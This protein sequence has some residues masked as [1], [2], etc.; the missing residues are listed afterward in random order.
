MEVWAQTG[1]ESASRITNSI[2]EAMKATT[3]NAT[4]TQDVEFIKRL[5]G[6]RMGVDIAMCDEKIFSL[7]DYY[8]NPS[9]VFPSPAASQIVT[10]IELPA[11]IVRGGRQIPESMFRPLFRAMHQVVVE[12]DDYGHGQASDTLAKAQDF[13]AIFRDAGSL[14][15]AGAMVAEALKIRLCKILGLDTADKTIHDRMDSFGVDSLIALELRN[16]LAKEV[17]AHLAM[18]EILGDVELIDTG[19]TAARKSEF[20]QAGWDSAK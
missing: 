7:F 6:G 10:D 3:Y 12:G 8:C 1:P 16:W 13:A 20:R 11:L 19:L 18:Y 9:T 17:R 4:V 5:P 2:K 15:E 14:V